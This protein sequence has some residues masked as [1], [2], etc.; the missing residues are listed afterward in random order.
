MAA[1]VCTELVQTFFLVT[2][3]TIQYKNDLR[4]IDTV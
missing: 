2:P 1:S 3:Y 4:T